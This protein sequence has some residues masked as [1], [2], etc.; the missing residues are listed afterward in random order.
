MIRRRIGWLFTTL[1]IGTDALLIMFS[2]ALAWQLRYVLEVGGAVAPN[3]FM[4]FASYRSTLLAFT[5]VMLAV[6]ALSG[7]YRMPRGRSF[8]VEALQI[9]QAVLAA[10][11][12]LVIALF[13]VR[14]PFSS[15]LML[16]YA[17][18]CSIV[19]LTGARLVARQIKQIFWRRGIGVTR[20]LVVGDGAAARDVMRDL[21][22]HQHLGRQLWGCLTPDMRQTNDAIIV[23]AGRPQIVPVR[24]TVDDLDDVMLAESIRQV[25][26]ALPGTMVEATQRVV[27]VCERRHVD[28]RLAPELYGIAAHQVAVDTT[29]HR[30]VLVIHELTQRSRRRVVKRLVDIAL[31]LLVMM[32]VGLLLTL[33]IAILI[34]LD[35]PGPIFFR[36]KRMTLDGSMFWVYK[37]RSMYVDAE[38]R[39]AALQ[40]SNEAQGP[41][42]KM[43]DDPR[44]TRVGKWL[45][46][47][48]MDELPQV[49]NILMGEMS[50][51][52]P[53]PPLPAE[54]DMYEPW[55][56]RRL[57]STT[58]LTGLW[59]VSGRSLLSFED[60]VKLDLYYVE[61]WSLWL[62]FKIICMTVPA[63]LSARGAY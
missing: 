2:F 8:R 36:Q 31:S 21:L 11:G 34:K 27:Q 43:R 44:I 26:I 13:L 20:V 12:L 40:A 39:R 35:S 51:V 28:F 14:L 23:D 48:S 63:V 58:G 3:F 55:Q 53:R 5:A 61:N 29:Y 59:Q 62:D 56:K 33:V 24:G 1:T 22:V 37:F 30:P 60:M 6:F 45:R 25:I 42:F 7:I 46:R 9:V 38:A 19:F 47:T 32:P 15:R 41:I 52:G 50:W 18:A 17:G 54:V 10:L 4:P 57:G 49:F 16:A